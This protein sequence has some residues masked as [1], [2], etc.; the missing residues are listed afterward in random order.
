GAGGAK[1]GFRANM[2]P[3]TRTPMNGILGMTE[4]TLAT[5]LS[6]E[7]RDY[8]EMVKL[9]ADALLTIINDIL[10]FSKI[11]AHKLTLDAVD[12]SLRDRVGDMMKALALRA[13]QKGLE[14]A[15]HIPPDVTDGLHGDPVRLQ[16]ILLNLAGNAVK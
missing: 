12:F 11:E 15:C 9:S 13:Q 10:D 5:D 4:L 14:L 3:E 6:R 16:Q 8:L 2:G 1:G 7:Q